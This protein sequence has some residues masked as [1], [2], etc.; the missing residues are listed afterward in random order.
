MVLPDEI[1]ECVNSEVFKW[2]DIKPVSYTTQEPRGSTSITRLSNE[3]GKMF[4]L[5]V[6]YQNILEYI[7]YSTGFRSNAPP[8][9][10]YEDQIN[11]WK[12]GY[13]WGRFKLGNYCGTDTSRTVDWD[14]YGHYFWVRYKATLYELIPDPNKAIIEIKLGETYAGR[15]VQ[16]LNRFRYATWFQDQIVNGLATDLRK[17]G[18]NVVGYNIQDDVLTLN[19]NKTGSIALVLIGGYI[20]KVLIVFGL[21][22]IA[23]SISDALKT[24]AIVKERTESNR[25]ATWNAVYDNSVSSGATHEQAIEEANK[26][27]SLLKVQQDEFKFGEIFKYGSIFLLLAI[28]AAKVIS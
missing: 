23:Y 5:E 20:L 28:I 13:M 12:S 4:A 9:R 11:D 14:T 1:R 25:Q 24:R 2:T 21:T 19:V 15:V 3:M 27:V 10:S 22:I 18:W 17:E 16:S 6:D 7:Y 8:D 26:T